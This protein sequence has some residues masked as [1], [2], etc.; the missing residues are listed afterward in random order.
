MSANNSKQNAA[1]VVVLRE[2]PSNTGR[3]LLLTLPSVVGSI[4]F[5]V[6]L[7]GAFVA[8]VF[9]F[10]QPSVDTEFKA[11]PDEVIAD[12]VEDKQTETFNVTDVDDAKTEFDTNINYNV[13]RTDEPASVPGQVN[14]EMAIGI[15]DAPKDNPVTSIAPPG[16]FLTKG[17]GGAIETLNGPTTGPSIGDAGGY[18]LKNL[19]LQGSFYGR[20]GATKDAALRD[21]GGTDKSEAAVG[22]GLKWLVRQQ[23]SNG[24]WSLSASA[25]SNDV[26][27]T[28][29]G[30]LPFL[31]AG[32]THKAAQ[33]NAY[34]KVVLKGI[35]FL[36]KA[37]KNNKDGYF[38]GGMYAHGLATI[39]ICE[40]YGLTQDPTLRPV[41]SAA[42]NAICKAQDVAGEGGWGYNFNVAPHKDMSISGWQIMAMK[43][44][45]MAGITVP[46]ANV[47]KAKNYLE[48]S[49]K[50][51]DKGYGYTPNSGSSARM[52]AVGLLCRQ[53]MENWG[54]SNPNMIEAVGKHI[55]T[56][57]PDRQDCYYYY[58]ATQVMHHF[59][60]EEWRNWN[61]KMREY[62]IAKQEMNEKSPNFGSWSPEGDPW[63]R[64]GGRL[65]ITSLNLLTLEVYYRYL[66]LYYRDAGYGKDAAVKNAF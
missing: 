16:G 26:A 66:P 9:L 21:G 37:Q 18:G 13:E 41:A 52:T 17:T 38:G 5:H 6:L 54:P 35:N 8:Y 20:S 7:I 64:V 24:S 42:I 32:K 43:S 50:S 19:P 62:L 4:I 55:K 23:L 36:R 30:L 47:K 57:P 14:P 15:R 12:K 44:G 28:A 39:A 65:M 63:A 53:Y 59:G 45:M 11:I 3:Y 56:N 58:Y 27:G 25:E 33:D 29:L 51:G 22:R 34:D 49:M 10:A 61:E 46:E 2:E 48:V 1:P 60:G 31:A 40:A